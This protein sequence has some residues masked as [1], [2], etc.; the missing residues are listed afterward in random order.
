ML[1]ATIKEVHWV[2][3]S[4]LHFQQPQ[5]RSFVPGYPQPGSAFLPLIFPVL[6][7]PNSGR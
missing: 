4:H 2:S 1:S 6:R 3:V 5:K 7:I